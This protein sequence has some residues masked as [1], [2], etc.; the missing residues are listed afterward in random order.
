MI[1]EENQVILVILKLTMYKV[2]FMFPSFNPPQQLS[3]VGTVTLIWH[4][5]QQD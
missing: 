1:L 2:L 4:M 5:K 3:R